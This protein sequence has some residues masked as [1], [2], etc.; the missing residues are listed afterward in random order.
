MAFG[1]TKVFQNGVPESSEVVL[2]RLLGQ[3]ALP[4][5]TLG[6]QRVAKKIPKGVFWSRFGDPKAEK[7][8]NF[9]KPLIM[10]KSSSRV[11]ESSIFEV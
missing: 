4:E 3:D 7:M 11:H 1:N 5:T 2:R 8:C 10:S 6:G 9:P